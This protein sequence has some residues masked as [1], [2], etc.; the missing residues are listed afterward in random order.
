MWLINWFKTKLKN[1][2]EIGLSFTNEEAYSNILETI[3]KFF[4]K[5]CQLIL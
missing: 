4:I 2:A 5:I 1:N 3:Y